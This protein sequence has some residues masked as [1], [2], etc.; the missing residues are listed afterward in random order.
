MATLIIF[1][2]ETSLLRAIGEAHAQTLHEAFL[3][4]VCQAT[5]GL[6]ARRVLAAAG[7]V[8]DARRQ[9]VAKSQRLEV[10]SQAGDWWAPLARG[11]VVS[12]MSNAPTLPR[13]EVARALDLLLLNDVVVGPGRTRPWLIGVRSEAARAA[14]DAA[15]PLAGP[16][17]V[18][19]APYD[20][21]ED[22]ADLERLR[23][24][25]ETLPPTVAA[26]TRRALAVIR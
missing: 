16:A 22:A 13:A 12:V 5:A 6:G 2:R 1:E 24:E 19:V 15:E 26:A 9:H 20:L 25:L 8:D 18:T 7:D 23:R 14:F 21:V 17:A 11:P 3:E 4:D 10:V